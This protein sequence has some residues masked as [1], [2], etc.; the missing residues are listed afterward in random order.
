M[1]NTN[2]IYL[3]RP[4]DLGRADPSLVEYT[5]GELQALG[6]PSY[7]PLGAFTVSGTPSGVVQ[8]VNE[9]AMLASGGAVAF[10]P[11]GVQ[12][13]GVPFEISYLLTHDVPTLVVTDL[14][15]R[16]WMMASVADNSLGHVVSLDEESVSAGLDWL[17][18]EVTWRVSL[19]DHRLVEPIVFERIRPDALLPTQGYETDAGYDLYAVESVTVP[20]RG[21]V[22]VSCGV[23]ADI[24]DGLWAQITGRSSTLKKYSLMVAPTTGVIDEGYTGELF[25]PVVSLNDEDVKIDAGQRIAQ[26]IL[27]EAPGQRYRPT[28]GVCR[29]K[30][31]GANGFGSTGR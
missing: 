1:A 8:R 31:R 24:P 9:A 28:W 23:A 7:D 22:S 30:D 14:G 20:A 27:H 5:V 10:I 13:V 26:F 29:V 25:A 6:F 18:D 12:S 16:S 21:Q 19:P 4:I 11:S 2:L 17:R 15:S 3:A